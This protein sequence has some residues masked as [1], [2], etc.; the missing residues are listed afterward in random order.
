MPVHR[1]RYAAHRP[2]RSDARFL[3]SQAASPVVVF[4]QREVRRDLPSEMTL[5]ALAPEHV[6]E[7]QQE[8]THGRLTQAGSCST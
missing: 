3:R 2:P 4:E 1:Q 6:E 5:G 7:P 8:S